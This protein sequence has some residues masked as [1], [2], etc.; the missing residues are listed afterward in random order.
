LPPGAK[1]RFQVYLAHAAAGVL[2]R[3]QSKVAFINFVQDVTQLCDCVALSG[4]PVVPDI[5]ILASMDVVAVDKASLDL[6]AKS[7]PLGKLADISS[8]DILGKINGTDSLIQIRTAHAL[9]L[10]S[11][12]YEL[13]KE[14]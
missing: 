7:R 4:F 3:F 6:I 5:G 12:T 14:K 11:M 1:E 13:K 10:G 8:P 2:G 9:G